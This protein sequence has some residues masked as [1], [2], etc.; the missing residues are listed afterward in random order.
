MT[1]LRFQMA[2]KRSLMIVCVV[3]LV[4][5][6]V[7][8][9][10]II[11]KDQPD[12]VFK[13]TVL[14]KGLNQGDTVF[15]KQHPEYIGM[16]ET[17][18]LD[19]LIVN[20][21]KALFS[22]LA[23]ETPVPAELYSPKDTLH[24][25][26][27]FF[28]EPGNIKVDL[29][30]ADDSKVSGTETNDNLQAFND[31]LAPI[32]SSLEAIQQEVYAN[33]GSWDDI[34]N[35]KRKMDDQ[36]RALRKCI[37]DE[38]NNNINNELGIY[39]LLRYGGLLEYESII[40]FFQKTPAEVLIRPGFRQMTGANR[41]AEKAAN[42]Q[43]GQKLTDFSLPSIDG[44]TISAME[45][46]SRNNITIIDFWA[47]WCGPCMREMP[48]MRMLYEDYKDHGLQ[49]IG[50]S[51][52]SD[53]E[54]WKSAISKNALTWHHLSDMQG[55]DGPVVKQF[56][57]VSIP[58]TIVVDSQGNILATGLRGNELRKLIEEK[59]NKNTNGE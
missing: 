55:W 22:G 7:A 41:M 18:R 39:V 32:V 48:S 17:S 25:Q 42:Q 46:V 52:D 47:S 40:D 9:F 57:V 16:D 3:A 38:I 29:S 28:I 33:D 49:I 13:L 53:P 26:A 50:V 59:I 30:Q 14:T 4:I 2:K 31:R 15:L 8:A 5:A 21:D 51:L 58:Y 12:N 19:T 43:I 6:S 54:D 45:I 36:F 34:Q 1:N 24:Y 10:S 44:D 35:S 56:G 37:K 11:R 20:N 27:I 23:M